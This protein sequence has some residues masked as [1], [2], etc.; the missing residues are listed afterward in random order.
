MRTPFNNGKIKMGIAYEP[1][2]Y[3]ETDPDM[4]FLQ[5]CLIGDPAIRRKQFYVKLG[6]WSLLIFIVLIIWLRS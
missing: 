1:Q 6:Y 4:L 3:V 2:Q 5:S